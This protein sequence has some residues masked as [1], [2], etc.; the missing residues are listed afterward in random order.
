MFK[1]GFDAFFLRDVAN[2]I[3]GGS[4]ILQYVMA[5]QKL[6]DLDRTLGTDRTWEIMNGKIVCFPKGMQET[7]IGVIYGAMLLPEDLETDGWIQNYA[8]EHFK[9]MLGRNRDK[10]SGFNTSAGTSTNDGKTLIDEALS[11]K[12]ILIEELK[13]RRPPLPILKM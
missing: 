7:V 1:I 9:H 6:K 5:R 3:I 10:I 2:P 8:V 13:S 12:K 4:D 11:E